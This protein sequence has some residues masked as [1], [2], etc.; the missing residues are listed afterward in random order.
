MN[1]WISQMGNAS[2][3]IFFCMGFFKT[4]YLRQPYQLVQSIYLFYF[5]QRTIDLWNCVSDAGIYLISMHYIFA[6]TF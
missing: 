6:L 4:I 3:K 5:R 2:D 1:E